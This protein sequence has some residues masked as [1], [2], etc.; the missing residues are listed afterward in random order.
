MISFENLLKE[1]YE[2]S[3]KIVPKRYAE[4]CKKSEH[5]KKAVDFIVNI[6]KQDEDKFM[7]VFLKNELKSSV[8]KYIFNKTKETI[9][10]IENLS[11]ISGVMQYNIPARKRLKKTPEFRL[12]WYGLKDNWG[13]GMITNEGLKIINGYR[14]VQGYS[15][16]KKK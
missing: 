14:Q 1:E 2:K 15:P 7:K 13:G 8:S 5:E 6:I 10:R 11:L 16:V 9:E 12:G 3:N 4:I